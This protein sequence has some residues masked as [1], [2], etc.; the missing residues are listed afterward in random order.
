MS[1][2]IARL[3]SWSE[4]NESLRSKPLMQGNWITLHRKIKDHWIYSDAEKLKAWIT[5]LLEVNHSPQKILIKNEVVEVG[6]GESAKSLDTWAK[7][8]G[9][10]W[11]RSKVRRFI[12]VLKTDTMVVTIP[13]HN[14]THLRV[15]NYDAYQSGRIADETQV[16]RK[17]KAN[18]KQTTTNNNGNNGNNEKKE[19]YRDIQGLILTKDEYVKLL[20]TYSD[21]EIEDVLE[22][23]ENY[24]DLKKK[25]VS[26][27]KTANNWLKRRKAESAQD[28]DWSKL[29]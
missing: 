3:M 4:K 28:F 19:V 9:K 10:G 12:S 16:K 8:F 25:Y 7:L 24:K 2:P 22:S 15:C 6:R 23:M 1:L 20:E 26:A 13:T 21:L 18:E 5:I 17:R 27:Y 11:N 14:T 29:K